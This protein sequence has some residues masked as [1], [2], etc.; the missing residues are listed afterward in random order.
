[1]TRPGEARSGRRA[2]LLPQ[3]GGDLRQP[4]IQPL[5]GQHALGTFVGLALHVSGTDRK[6]L[7]AAIAPFRKPPLTWEEV[8]P[9]LEDVFIH[10]MSRQEDVW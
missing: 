6:A 9:T 5:I 3:Q 7:E 1:M 10:L 8:E 4:R 2:E